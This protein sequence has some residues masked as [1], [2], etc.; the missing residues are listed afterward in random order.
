M[1]IPVVLIIDAQI[2]EITFYIIN[3]TFNLKAS[4]KGEPCFL[5]VKLTNMVFKRINFWSLLYFTD[6]NPNFFINFFYLTPLPEFLYYLFF[7]EAPI[8]MQHIQP[9]D[10]NR[11]FD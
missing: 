2:I 6:Y 9:H 3:Y 8:M 1:R 11:C 7:T 4:I 5:F 10:Q